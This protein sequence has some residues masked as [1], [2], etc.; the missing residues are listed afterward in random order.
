MLF[1]ELKAWE[2]FV[3]C[4]ILPFKSFL[5]LN[6][7]PTHVKF[8]FV[9]P[10]LKQTVIWEQERNRETQLMTQHSSFVFLP[11]SDFWSRHLLITLSCSVTVWWKLLLQMSWFPLCIRG[12]GKRHHFL[13]P[14]IHR[15][16][17]HSQS[18][19]TETFALQTGAWKCGH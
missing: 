3:L 10:K 17:K 15:G 9:L 7:Y 6:S 2:A 16:R 13:L 14:W 5:S 8:K 4:F 19:C 1:S 12:G 11:S 18:C